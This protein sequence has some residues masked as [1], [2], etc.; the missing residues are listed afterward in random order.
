MTE[1]I[2]AYET[3]G[4]TLRCADKDALKDVESVIVTLTQYRDRVIELADGELDVDAD[5]AQIA[6]SLTQEQTA[7]LAPGKLKLQVNV[8]YEDGTRVA[9]CEH[10]IEVRGNA[11]REVM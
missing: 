4:F 1:H 8:K 10:E 5:A 6:F 3:P 2:H 11:H 7:L 9:S